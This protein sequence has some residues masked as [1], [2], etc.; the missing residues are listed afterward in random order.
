MKFASRFII[1]MFLAGAV[2]PAIAFGADG[3]LIEPGRGV[4]ARAFGK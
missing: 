4:G 2:A 3:G 1:G